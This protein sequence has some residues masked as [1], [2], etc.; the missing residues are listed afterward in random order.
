MDLDNS[1]E[2]YGVMT[3]LEKWIFVNSQHTKILIDKRNY[4]FFDKN[5]IPDR[6]QLEQII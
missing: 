2:A 6:K 3:N 5:S 1:Q 4:L